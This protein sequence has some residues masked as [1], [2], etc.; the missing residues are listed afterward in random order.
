MVKATTTGA[1]AMALLAALLAGPATAD[2]AETF[3]K[4]LTG[5]E[6]TDLAPIL[7]SP[8]DG[9]RVCVEGT[10]AAVCHNRGCWL[11]LQQGEASVHVTFEGYS[12]FVPKDS[13]GRRVRLEGS[14]KVA[15]PDPERVE[16]LQSEGAS[17][18]AARRVS[19]VATGVE[20]RPAE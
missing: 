4:P 15:D 14:V 7:A 10:V 13:K 9:A 20:L 8:E 17:D 11:E 3:G 6:A 2:E 18:A 1:V 19:I 16:H 5:M 12:F